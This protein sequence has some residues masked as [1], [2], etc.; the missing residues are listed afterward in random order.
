MADAEPRQIGQHLGRMREGEV[1]VELQAVGRPRRRPGGP[2]LAVE[3]AALVQRDGR[4]TRERPLRRQQPVDGARQLP[5]PVGMAH[6]GARQV[7][8]VELFQHVL[9]LDRRQHRLGLRDEAE[10]RL[11]R[12]LGGRGVR[13][14]HA[15][16][17]RRAREGGEIA[18]AFAALVL[19]L[20][21]RVELER[22]PQIGVE[23]LPPAGEGRQVVRR[24][25]RQRLARIGRRRLER[26][27]LLALEIDDAVA[28]NVGAHDR[29]GE[30]FGRG[31]EVLGD[32]ERARTMA[33]DAQHREHRR[34]GIIDVDALRRGIP[35][36]TT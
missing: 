16:L 14:L 24:D 34:E 23:T 36:G 2:A 7:G 28:Q 11:E 26:A 13:G 30:A 4:G 3:V 32:D 17:C 33:L 10:R 5:P 27:T 21:R 6:V 19:R 25:R 8:L 31:A 20:L 12:R 35:S 18:D 29:V 22:L 1:L 15:G 9:E